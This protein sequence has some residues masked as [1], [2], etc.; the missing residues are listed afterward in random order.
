M[1]ITHVDTWSFSAMR[2]TLKARFLEKAKEIHTDNWQ[3]IPV[4]N[5]PSARMLE[6]VNASMY[7]PKMP[8]SPELLARD[9]SR[10]VN[11]PWAE[12]HFF[13]RVCGMPINPGEE[14]ANW[15]DGGSAARFLDD[16]GMFNHNYMERFWPRLAGLVESPTRN[17][18]EF[19]QKYSA[20]PVS[21]NR[22][23]R[24][25]YGDL[26]SLV[27]LLRSDPLTRQ[28][29]LPMFFPEDTGDANPGRKPCTLGYQFIRRDNLLHV[30]YPMRSCDFYRH[31]GDDVYM[32]VRLAMWVLERVKRDSPDWD[33]VE[34]G[35]YHMHCTSLHMFM[36]DYF[37]LK[38][39]TSK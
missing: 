30:Y 15:P 37:K 5:N 33:G 20:Q 24:G 10:A 35:S 21:E 14:W 16:R 3:G 22:G 2:N 25:L 11:L 23:I 18:D 4:K 38:E 1:T 28:A 6:L 13:E 9:L 32:A 19:I 29:Y 39:E 17:R 31:W 12:D 34:L 7:I 27:N 8:W 36:N 26:N